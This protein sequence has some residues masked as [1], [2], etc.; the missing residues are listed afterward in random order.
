M[1]A[2]FQ[3]TLVHQA[4]KTHENADH[5]SSQTFANSVT[6]SKEGWW[7]TRSKL[8]KKLTG[9]SVGEMQDKLSNNA[10]HIHTRVMKSDA[11]LDR[12]RVEENKLVAII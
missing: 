11:Q 3:Y 12:K 8:E 7:I 2:E 9:T 4:Q 5:L 1:L 10:A 6:S